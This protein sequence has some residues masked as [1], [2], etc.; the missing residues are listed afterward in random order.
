VASCTYPD[1]TNDSERTQTWKY[2][3]GSEGTFI[4]SLGRCFKSENAIDIDTRSVDEPNAHV[5]YDIHRDLLTLFIAPID[6]D[7]VIWTGR[8]ST[9]DEAFDKY[10]V[11]DV[12]VSPDLVDVVKRWTDKTDAPVFILHPTQEAFPGQNKLPRVD[13]TKLQNAIDQCRVIK[14]PHEIALI[15][16]ANEISADA[17]RTVLSNI[18]ALTN[19]TQVEGIFKDVCLSRGAKHQSYAPIAGSGENAAIL[20]YTKNDEPLEGRQLM[21]LD[22]GAEWCMYASDVTRSFPLHGDWSK[23][24]QATY[25]LVQ[26]MQDSC[27]EKIK[28]GTRF[29]DLHVLAHQI[30][31]HGLL[32]LG[33]LQNG[34]AEEILE[35]GSTLAFFPHGLGHHL[36]LEVHDVSDQPINSAWNGESAEREQLTAK[37]I[38]GACRSP[39]NKESGGLEEDMVLT[40]EPGIYFSRFAIKKFLESPVHSK[41]I[42][43]D[44]V[45]RYYPVGGVRIEDDILVNALHFHGRLTHPLTIKGDREWI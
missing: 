18:R 11:D 6:P 21:V 40:V 24:A 34:S 22:A 15:R 41:Y 44:V 2:R 25:D 29:L 28:P 31:V 7:R 12:Q 27:I 13:F 20:H 45:E 5:T 30:A 36:G 23:E 32:K 8:G 35:A 33:I 9:I 16:K 37:L 39:V 26:K 10:D 14:D 42:N 19:E 43:K 4:M 3:S 38:S 1:S 17:H